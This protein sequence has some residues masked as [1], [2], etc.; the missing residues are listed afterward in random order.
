MNFVVCLKFACIFSRI[1]SFVNPHTSHPYE[2]VEL[3]NASNNCNDI[4]G[5]VLYL[6]MF[7]I[8]EFI[9]FTPLSY[10]VSILILK[11]PV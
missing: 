10:I 2:I 5:F 1:F 4:F 11:F 3:T 6:F 8:N 9:A 7:D